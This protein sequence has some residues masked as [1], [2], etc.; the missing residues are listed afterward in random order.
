MAAEAI[1]RTGQELEDT[2]GSI[3][4]VICTKVFDSAAE[5]SFVSDLVPALYP[6]EE[7]RYETL[8]KHSC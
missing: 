4:P 3:E 7:N 6:N 1:R 5:K 2:K 8:I